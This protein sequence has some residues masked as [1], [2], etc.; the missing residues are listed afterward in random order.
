MA[1]GCA[2]NELTGGLAPNEIGKYGWNT[3]NIKN[4]ERSINKIVVSEDYWIQKEVLP[5][6]EFPGPDPR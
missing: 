5:K 2:Q 1:G 6:E 4:P 3:A